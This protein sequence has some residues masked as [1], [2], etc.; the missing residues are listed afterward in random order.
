MAVVYCNYL[1]PYVYACFYW[2]LVLEDTLFERSS[3][4]LLMHCNNQLEYK[5]YVDGRSIL[6]VKYGMKKVFQY[7]D[8]ITYLQLKIEKWSKWSIEYY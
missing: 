3:I 2:V 6:P 5:S 8:L 7:D 1:S 4:T